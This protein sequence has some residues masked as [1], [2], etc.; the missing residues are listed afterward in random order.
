MIDNSKKTITPR[1][2]LAFNKDK[3]P[4]NFGQAN[5]STTNLS[6]SINQFNSSNK[7]NGESRL[8]T[9]QL[10]TTQSVNQN[11]PHKQSML[12]KFKATSNDNHEIQGIGGGS[13]KMIPQTTRPDMGQNNRMSGNDPQNLPSAI[14]K[15][16]S[17]QHQDEQFENLE[18]L[19]EDMILNLKDVNVD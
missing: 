19:N 11:V 1:N 3:P 5:Q 9:P 14:A 4:V 10:N 12:Q 18:D 8:P 17:A 15:Q 16:N 2:A 7:S 6:K 13:K